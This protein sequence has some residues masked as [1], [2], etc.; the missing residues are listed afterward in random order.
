MK[1]VTLKIEDDVYNELKSNV[2]VR[3]ISGGMYGVLD[4]FCLKLFKEMDKGLEEIH[5]EFKKKGQED[6]QKTKTHN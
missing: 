4:A 1:I 2:F 3:G 5:F 6:G